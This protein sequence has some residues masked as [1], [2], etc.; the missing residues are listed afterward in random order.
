MSVKQRVDAVLKVDPEEVRSVMQTPEMIL[1]AF[2]VECDALV[3]ELSEQEDGDA[4]GWTERLQAKRKQAKAEL[5]ALRRE[6]AAHKTQHGEIALTG[7]LSSDA[8]GLHCDFSSSEP[9]DKGSVA[10]F[11]ITTLEG[12]PVHGGPTFRA[13]GPGPFLRRIL[14][15]GS[16]FAFYIPTCAIEHAAAGRYLLEVRVSRP[17]GNSGI[18]E[19]AVYQDEIGLA[20]PR[21]W[22]ME[23]VYGPILRLLMTMVIADGIMEREEISLLQKFCENFLRMD[24]S[25][26]PEVIELLKQGASPSIAEDVALIQYRFPHIPAIVIIQMLAMICR[27]DG[28]IHENELNL[29]RTVAG[30]FGVTDPQWQRLIKVLKLDSPPQSAGEGLS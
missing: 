7:S 15:V 27:V 30:H 17:D 19:V 26:F 3:E 8:M 6:R 1:Q 12:V 14:V 18:E 5:M 9:L 10:E 11:R 23:D 20:E 13:G 25:M 24:R 22:S 4:A 2:I 28:D 29:C 16:T 21:P